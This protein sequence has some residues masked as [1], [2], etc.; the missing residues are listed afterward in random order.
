MLYL[1][2]NLPESFVLCERRKVFKSFAN[3]ENFSMKFVKYFFIFYY[4]A[5]KYYV[6]VPNQTIK[7]Y[8][9]NVNVSMVQPLSS[10]V[11]KK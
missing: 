2:R 7:T 11:G 8:R 1:L 9:N 10:F 3:H 6:C 5:S 4:L